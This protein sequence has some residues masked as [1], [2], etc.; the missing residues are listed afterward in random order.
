LFLL[1]PVLA[2]SLQEAPPSSVSIL[3][4]L[5]H[6]YALALAN[7]R[8]GRATEVDL[9]S[10]KS[11]RAQL[12]QLFHSFLPQVQQQARPA[13]VKLLAHIDAVIDTLNM[14]IAAQRTTLPQ[15]ADMLSNQGGVN[16]N[17]MLIGQH[18][19]RSSQPPSQRHGVLAA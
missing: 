16:A 14:Q 3:E 8:A 10:L 7:V 6:Q 1:N 11:V 17:N 9:E 15:T 13:L 12:P 19:T 5:R 2:L 4:S 18:A